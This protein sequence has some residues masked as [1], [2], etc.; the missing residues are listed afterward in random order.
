MNYLLS[1]AYNVKIWIRLV[2]TIW[3]MLV[4]AWSGIVYWASWEQRRAAI[5]QARYFADSVHQM[6]LAGLTGMM[7]TGT[8]AQRAIFLDQ[9]KNSNDVNE[10]RVLRGDAV[11]KQFGAGT[12]EESQRDSTEQEALQSG[13]PFYQ[14]QQEGAGE[15]LRVV[16]P[17]I[18]KSSYLGKNCLMCHTVPEGTVL[19]AVSMKLSL[20][21]ANDSTRD[22]TIKILA[23][24]VGASIPL[25]FA[26][27]LFITHFVTRPLREMTHSLHNIA[28]G[29]GDLTHRLPVR[30][31]DEI[32][33]AS[34]MFNRLLEKLG[35]LIGQISNSAGQVS[36]ASHQMTANAA[37]IAESSERQNEKSASAAAAMDEM[38]SGIAAVAGSAEEV[39]QASDE[40]LRRTE[41]S[42]EKLAQLLAQIQ[43]VEN[44][45]RKIAD[46]VNEF[47]GSTQSISA[48]TGQVKDI[49]NQTNL[50]ALNAAIEAARAGESGRGFA[51][52]AD[53]VRKLAEKSALSAQQ[54]DGITQV[55]AQQSGAIEMSIQEGVTELRASNDS[56]REV[57]AVLAE[58]RQSV[59]R[60]NEGMT[61]IHEATI[62]QR[63]ASQSVTGNV[64][65]IAAMAEEN[66]LAIER[67]AR[68]AEHL[69]QLAN[70]LQDAVS[71][72][73]Y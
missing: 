46:T 32:G 61:A 30:G 72:F 40:S 26:I 42:D 59:V 36:E 67:A 7:M 19:G 34:T 27:Y 66:T 48:M 63:S 11:S 18:A 47:I 4:I 29:E 43:M 53:E 62:N 1:K 73:K 16:L 6:T 31:N 22:F 24:A 69:E 15:V 57:S 28:E 35:N 33:Q 5:E 49:A 39:Q 38:T 20:K 45:F 9:I 58:A 3:V 23:V 52:V 13:K 17:S 55:I 71:R 70:S 41:Q 14:V 64:A 8:V 60:V 37:Q 44:A 54:I 21:R 65:A 50:L 51:V 10:L 12:A 56:M 25:L 68:A 2:I